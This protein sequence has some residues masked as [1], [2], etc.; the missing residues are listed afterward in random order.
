MLEVRD[1]NTRCPAPFRSGRSGRRAER[2]DRRVL[3]D[4]RPMDV[5]DSA[6]VQ[7]RLGR[8]RTEHPLRNPVH[9]LTRRTV[10]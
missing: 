4:Q 6:D 7:R 3:P 5:L 10:D 9:R 2:G 1:E 8:R